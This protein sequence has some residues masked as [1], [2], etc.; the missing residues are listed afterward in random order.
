MTLSGRPTNTARPPLLDGSLTGAKPPLVVDMDGTLLRTDSLFESA[1]QLVRQKPWLIALFP[2]WLSGGK[3]RLK[4]QIARRIALDV[5]ALPYD[6]RLIERLRNERAERRLVLCTA[7]DHR[8][9]EAVAAHVG[10]FDE[11]MASSGSVNLSARDKARALVERFGS[12]GFDYVG[13]DVAD[14]SVFA[15]ARRAMVINPTFALRRRMM[16][17]DAA[18]LERLDDTDAPRSRALLSYARALRPHQWAKNLLVFVPVLATLSVSNLT[19]FL[20]ATLAFVAFC[21]VASAGYLVNDLVDISADRRHPRKRLRSLA[22]GAVPIQHAMVLVPALLTA[23]FVVAA[24]VSL[25]F[26]AVLLVYGVCSALYTFWLKR[27]PLL[28]TL[29]LAG[30]YTVRILAGAAAITVVPS[31]WL[32]A[33]SM[34]FFLSLALAKRH[35]ELIEMRET[36]DSDAIPG[37]DYGREDLSTLISQGSASGYAAVLVLAL[38]VDSS[39]VRQEYRHPEVIWLICPLVLYWI[40]K[41]WLNSQRG[42]INDDPVVWA[43]KNRV[44]RGIAALSVAVLLLARWWP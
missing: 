13:N 14:L 36:L 41:L 22:A 27:V 8:V 6:E 5:E 2:W 31:V 12:G 10:V 40:N 19:V 34:F 16:S 11:V 4:E 37:R 9:A 24:R 33:F 15:E 35:S 20:P 26:A 38:Y 23:G 21:L 30:L 3:A 44:S 18:N 42:Q 7:A 25:L 29:M 28:D 39:Q 32:L 43:I 17:G 1:V